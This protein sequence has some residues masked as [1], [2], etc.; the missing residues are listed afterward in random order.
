MSHTAHPCQQPLD[1]DTRN[2]AY[3]GIGSRQ[4]P[5]AVLDAMARIAHALGNAGV[6]LSTGGADGADKAFETGA[7]RTRAPLTRAS[8]GLACK[9]FAFDRCLRSVGP[10]WRSR[11]HF[12]AKQIAPPKEWSQ[13]EDLCL[14]L[15]KEVW[16]DPLAQKNGRKGQA[17]RGVDVYGSQGGYPGALWGVQCKGKDANYG[18]KPTRTE[19]EAELT[20]AE[21]FKPTL[22]GWVFATTAPTD[23]ALQEAAREISFDRAKRGDFPVSVLGWEE[24]QALLA[25]APKV[26][27]S[28]YPEHSNKLESVVEALEA[29]PSRDESLRL[30][31]RMEEVHAALVTGVGRPPVAGHWQQIKLGNGRD[32]G[33]A[34]MGRRLGP[35]DAAACPRL[36]EADV[37]L[38]QLKM[39]FSARIIGEPGAGKSVCAYQAALTLAKVGHDVMRLTDPRSEVVLP[40]TSDQETL[41]LV[42]MRT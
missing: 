16:K 39:A 23:G 42:T 35:E 11:L 13:F 30:T 19:L 18:G 4:T 40:E 5:P 27:A 31:R 34:L 3:A 12:L 25:T 22:A 20:K 6:A 10:P 14:A 8:A 38:S 21:G 28:F 36:D 29:L 2:F 7:L 37:V 33:P 9:N 41:F 32:L 24:I 15:F 1:D 17:Q 26:I